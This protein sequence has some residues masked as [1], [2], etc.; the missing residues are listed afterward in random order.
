[1]LYN[2]TKKWYWEMKNHICPPI[3]EGRKHLVP[4][5][6]PVTR[7]I[8]FRCSGCSQD[9]FITLTAFKEREYI[10]DNFFDGFNTVKRRQ[11]FAEI[12]NSDK[13][14]DFFFEKRTFKK[15]NRYEILKSLST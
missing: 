10:R 9:F 15:P 2:D 4:N 8:G 1:M 5:D 12:L 6:D 13:N 3:T 14:P 11:K 7:F